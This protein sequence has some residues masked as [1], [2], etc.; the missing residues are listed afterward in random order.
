MTRSRSSV[1]LFA[2]GLILLGG[3]AACGGGTTTK[4]TSAAAAPAV[5]TPSIG[6]TTLSTVK[7]TGGGDY[8]TQIADGLNSARTR[9]GTASTVPAS[10]AAVRAKIETSRKQYRDSLNSAPTEI[11]PDLE[12]FYAASTALYDSLARVGYDYAKLTPADYRAYSTPKLQAA[13][14]HVFGYIK[15]H[16]GIDILH[17]SSTATTTP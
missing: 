12:V 11:K 6:A 14:T 2:L 17:G 7:A 1:A 3:L 16:C 10:P 8:C 5:S 4:T 9:A 15:D 13:S